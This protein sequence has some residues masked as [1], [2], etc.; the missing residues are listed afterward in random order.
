MLS[1]TMALTQDLKEK[2]GIW[3]G[4]LEDHVADLSCQ[5]DSHS[6]IMSDA[7]RQFHILQRKSKLVPSAQVARM[8][9]KRKKG[10]FLDKPPS[11][12]A[13]SSQ[14]Q[15]EAEAHLHHPEPYATLNIILTLG[16]YWGHQETA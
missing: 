9:S 5:V 16:E 3:D 1:N 2:M 14:P 11:P 7:T 10:M 4:K 13:S 15:P 12:Q 8:T 6:N